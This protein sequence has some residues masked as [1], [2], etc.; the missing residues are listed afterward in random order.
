MD[1]MTSSASKNRTVHWRSRKTS[2][3]PSLRILL[4]L[5]GMVLLAFSSLPF[6]SFPTLGFWILPLAVIYL[7]TLL[8]FPRL[9][10]FLLPLATVSLDLTTWTGR[11]SYNEFDYVMLLTLV[12]G[13]VY[14]RY[15]LK[16][17]TPSTSM[18]VALLYF[19]VVLIGYSGWS[20]FVFAPQAGHDNPYY[21]DEYAYK[22][23]RGLIWAV[24]LVP[25]WGHLL[26]VD[27]QRTVQALMS[28]ICV[29]AVVLGIIVMWERGTLGLLL[30]GS[31]WYHVV[32]SLLDLSSSY[33]VTALFSDMHTGGE[34]ID[35]VILLFLPAT[36]YGS[37]HG[38]KVYLRLLA[39]AAFLALAYV[40]LVGFTRT[41]YVAF[42]LGV[43]LYMAV[44]YWNWR[45]AGLPP[46]VPVGL[47]L[48]TLLVGLVSAT[49][50][51]KLAGSSGLAS[52][53]ILLVLAFAGNRIRDSRSVRVGLVIGVL[54]LAGYAVNAHFSSRWVES[55]FPAAALVFAS[56]SGAFVLAFRL[57][58]LTTDL[59]EVDRLFVL[60]FCVLLP[61]LSA[62]ALG[63]YQVGD[64]F[65]HIS[66]D[67]GVRQLHW[68]QVAN[69][70]EGALAGQA[71][72]SGI[73][74][75]PALYIAAHPEQ[76]GEVGSFTIVSDDRRAQLHIG[77][78][79]D[80][81]FGQRL[82]IEP[83]TTYKVDMRVRSKGGSYL[84]ISLCERN[85][86]YATNFIPQCVHENISLE[87]ADGQFVDVSAE[88]Y[89]GT[90]GNRGTLKRW[91]TL[92][93]FRNPVV[94]SIVE[95]D[96]IQ[97]S[98]GGFNLLQNSSFS[99]G[100]DNWFYYYDYAHLPWH[101]KNGF[102]QVWYELGW[103]GLGLFLI[104]LG[105]LGHATF[106]GHAADS[107]APVYF[108]G[109]VT[110]CIF[111]LFGS[112]LDSARVSWLFYFYLFAGLASLR[113]GKRKRIRR[114]P[115]QSP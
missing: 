57:F 5:L 36:V 99:R 64:R 96:A 110:V 100:L 18:V 31:A 24:A 54:I 21:T 82:T 62:F 78:G 72:G 16:V 3:S 92:F 107:L 30:S 11:F 91:P 46:P 37:L 45:R 86:L 33:R 103:L 13:L 53:G 7:S 83:D 25:M 115:G 19:L 74:R 26:A 90:I 75:F 94:H 113:V 102:L 38:G 47:L 1:S 48:V 111:G 28:G 87:N 8:V 106:R 15:R 34:V 56:L 9:W 22:V 44:S 63:G 12:S 2:V 101:I 68:Q 66:R 70:F 10:L 58:R 17:Y 89:S 85:I 4:L 42:A 76:V 6:F 108:V 41:T 20:Y 109:V 65:T 40:A 112:P 97:L 27:K 77:G 104:L 29:A 35:G 81:V 50:V 61:V 60:A 84:K 98:A 105:L 93:T 52:F 55:S 39:I 95:I 80:L 49:I 114:P 67:L 23:V 14:G 43:A 88:I 73:G 32:N 59:P 79:K 71:L 51:Y 69:S